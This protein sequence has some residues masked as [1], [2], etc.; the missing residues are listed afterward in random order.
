HRHLTPAQVAHLLL[1]GGAH[2]E[3][4]EMHGAVDDASSTVED[5]H[6][7]IRSDRFSRAGLA[8]DADRLALADA[9]VDVL[10]RAH[11]PAPRR[12]LDGEVGDIE[13]RNGLGHGI[14]VRRCGSTMSR[15]PSP[16][17]LKQK[18]AIISAAPGKNAI[19]HSPDTMKAAPSAT[20]IPHSAVGGRTPRPMKE[21]PAA[22]RMAYPMVS[23]ICTTMI[24][25]M[26]GRTCA[27]R[28]RISPLP[29]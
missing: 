11:D 27:S 20:I 3:P 19:H 26:F 9:H 13:Q 6:D 15:R 10:H 21:R 2:V 8:D 28:M 14:H 1:A 12:E 4:R 22:L 25:M 7:R 5:A 18:T 29:Q 16:S 24:G 23:D 17:R